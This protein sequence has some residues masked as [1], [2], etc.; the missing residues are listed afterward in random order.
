MSLLLCQAPGLRLNEPPTL[1]GWRPCQKLF[2]GAILPE[3]E[4]VT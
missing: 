3:I 1:P 4:P 2:P